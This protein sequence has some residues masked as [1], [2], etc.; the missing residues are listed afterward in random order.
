[1]RRLYELCGRNLMG[2]EAREQDETFAMY[3]FIRYPPLI[4]LILFI[5][6]E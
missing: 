4:L 6:I 3:T 2:L 1:M 5:V